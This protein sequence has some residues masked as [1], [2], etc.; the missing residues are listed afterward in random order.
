MFED[1]S[2]WLCVGV[3]CDVVF[4]GVCAC[5][6]VCLYVCVSLC[7]LCML[8]WVGVCVTVSRVCDVY[9]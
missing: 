1:V 3:C 7:V 2:G 9:V 4:M 5:V 6:C 8:M